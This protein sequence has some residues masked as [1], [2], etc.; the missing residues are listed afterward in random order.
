[1]EKLKNKEVLSLYYA[2][3]SLGTLKGVKFN[4]VV[5]RNRKRLRKIVESLEEQ[6]KFSPEYE[7][8]DKERVKINEDF[9]EK[10]ADGSLKMVTHQSVTRYIIDSTRRE[11]FDKLQAELKGKY[12]KANEEREEQ[13]KEFKKLLEEESDF[14]PYPLEVN[15]IPDDITGSQFEIISAFLALEKETDEKEK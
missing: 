3:A 2:L 6:N 7:E 13:V 9:S 1:M 8:Y 15:C 4:Y 12:K 10:N 14:V 5:D 11:E